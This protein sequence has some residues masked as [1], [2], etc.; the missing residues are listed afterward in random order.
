MV[1]EKLDKL[2]AKKMEL[3]AEEAELR[4]K[5]E[6]VATQRADLAYAEY[7]EYKSSVHDK[8]AFLK[9]HSDVILP[10]LKHTGHGCSD[11]NPKNGWGTRVNGDYLCAKCALI[12]LMDQESLRVSNLITGGEIIRTFELD[13]HIF[14][15]KAPCNPKSVK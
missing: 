11:E 15:E 10:L 12:E 2:Y 3:D 4:R 8:Y 5:L 1:N 14:E 13:V 6:T 7:M 9:E